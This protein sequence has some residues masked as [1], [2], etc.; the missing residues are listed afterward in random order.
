MSYDEL[1]QTIRRQFPRWFVRQADGRPKLRIR[2]LRLASQ[3]LMAR[4]DRAGVDIEVQ[5]GLPTNEAL[6]EAAAGLPADRAYALGIGLPPLPARPRCRPLAAALGMDLAVADPVVDRLWF[7]GLE[8]GRGGRY[9]YIDCKLGHALRGLQ[10]ALP[11]NEWTGLDRRPAVVDWARQHVEDATF[12]LLP[13]QPPIDAPDRSFDGV[14]A[15]E[16]FPGSL[17][18][19]SLQAWL[20]E[21]G[22]LV[23]PGGFAMLA[24][25][26]YARL[27]QSV[28]RELGSSAELDRVYHALVASGRAELDNRGKPL[29]LYGPPCF[30]AA[31]FGDDWLVDTPAIGAGPNLRDVYLARR[32]AAST[33]RAPPIEI[34]GS[35]E[36]ARLTPVG[37]GLGLMR[38]ARLHLSQWRA[39][40]TSG[41]PPIEI[42]GL[43]EAA[44]PTPTGIKIGPKR[45]VRIV[46]AGTI[47]RRAPLILDDRAVAPD[48]RANLVNFFARV[49]TDFPDR[50]LLRFAD[51][52]VVGEGSVVLSDGSCHWLLA[53]SAREF[54]NKPGVAPKGMAVGRG[55]GTLVMP[56]HVSR[57]IDDCCLLLQRPWSENFGHWLVD[58]AAALSLLVESGALPTQHIIVTKTASLGLRQGI[59]QTIDAILPDA[60]VHEHDIREVWRCR[61]LAYLMPVHVPP[62][63]KLPAALQSLRKHLLP[64]PSP[65]RA[66]PPTRRLHVLRPRG[67]TRRLLNEAEILEISARHGFETIV[68]ETHSVREQARLFGEAESV[69]GVKGAALTNIIFAPP[70]C[71]VIVLSPGDFIDPFY[72]DIAGTHHAHYAE[73]FGTLAHEDR[74]TSHNDFT[75]DPTR[76]DAAL[77]QVLAA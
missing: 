35:V 22:R 62:L 67:R 13:E 58:Q 3:A 23:K 69:I 75:I 72:W 29:S 49:R 31:S 8:H 27:F 5:G 2:R 52:A 37:T 60:I 15:V 21:I 18:P 1:L 64:L 9:L 59:R 19:E 6:I 10:L 36:A 24:V 44:K 17:S 57:T 51:A 74:A 63:F 41:A 40:S 38:A 26:G 70:S 68:P 71:R 54:L 25:D 47:T 66:T 20:G 73:L 45:A 11:G 77:Q 46:E 42:T 56:G 76:F 28:L 30:A 14:I 50:Y 55:D 53:D 32:Q 12:A 65:S 48:L 33:S 34:A 4:L 7:A 16:A 61:D 43:V 39:T